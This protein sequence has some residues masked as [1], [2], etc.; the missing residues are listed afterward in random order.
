MDNGSMSTGSVTQGLVTQG[1]ASRHRWHP[2]EI[3]FWLAAL[4]SFVLLPSASIP[5]VG[6]VDGCLRARV[7]RSRR[8]SGRR[9]GSPSRHETWSG[10]A[11]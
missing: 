1:L 2:L 10:R 7:S 4:A 3:L 6:T 8:R 5:Y 9:S 11:A